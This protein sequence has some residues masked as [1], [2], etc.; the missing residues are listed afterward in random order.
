[1]LMGIL[2]SLAAL[3]APSAASGQAAPATCAV[4]PALPRE[5][6]RWPMRIGVSAAASSATMP[7]IRVD[8]AFDVT[9]VPGSLA[10]FIV[11]P[12]RKPETGGHAGLVEL[13]VIQPGLHQVALGSAAWV[14]I[15]QNGRTIA[16]VDHGHG[17]ECSGIRKIV[18]FNLQ[19]G[20]YVIQLS[21]AADP[22]LALMVRRREAR[23]LRQSGGL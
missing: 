8:Q 18:T 2:S 13:N 21:G 19:P 11:P 4:E 5:W 14:D 12:G 10:R 3:F 9:L 17:P 22:A 20:R 6:Q 16:S 15:V 7:V 23:E 1:M